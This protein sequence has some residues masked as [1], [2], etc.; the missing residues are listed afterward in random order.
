MRLAAGFFVILAA[1]GLFAFSYVFA[2]NG[3]QNEET[4]NSCVEWVNDFEKE[5]FFED[6]KTPTLSAKTIHFWNLLANSYEESSAEIPSNFFPQRAIGERD[7][8]NMLQDFNGLTKKQSASWF[9]SLL[10]KK[11][12][13]KLTQSNAVR[14][15][16]GVFELPNKTI[17]AEFRRVHPRGKWILRREATQALYRLA[18]K[19]LSESPEQSLCKKWANDDV[20]TF[21]ETFGQEEINLPANPVGTSTPNGTTS[22]PVGTSTSNGTTTS[23]AGTTTPQAQSPVQQPSVPPATAPTTS[24]TTSPTPS[25]TTDTSTGSSTGT[26][27]STSEGTTT[28]ASVTTQ[29]TLP[30]IS[31]SPP[32][33]ASITP[34]API[35]LNEHFVSSVTLQ[36]N[37]VTNPSRYLTYYKAWRRLG[38]GNW[39]LW[40]ET[41][42]TTFPDVMLGRGTYYYYVN[43]CYTSTGSPE[44]GL[45]TDICSPDS[46]IITATIAGGGNTSDMT[47]PSTPTILRIWN[48]D[49]PEYGYGRNFISWTESTDNVGVAGYNIYR[50]GTYLKSLWGTLGEDDFVSFSPTYAYTVAAYDA[51]G[52]IS[53]QSASASPTAQ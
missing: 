32:T 3:Q 1:V 46:N 12:N 33:I 35:A 7:F 23:G 9:N 28:P 45:V 50:N 26:G 37:A 21:N 24:P 16:S 2:Q 29:S 31:N 5:P 17:L 49:P 22:T 47:P 41:Q 11:T 4:I 42:Q 27:T 8:I 38:S 43:A 30:T 52:N 40:A 19:A 36:W 25:A 18:L 15:A 14:L 6:V 48:P 10:S 39:L 20:G 51:A 13:K 44:I 53:A 34:Y